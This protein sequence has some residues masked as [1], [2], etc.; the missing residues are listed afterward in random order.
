MLLI[1]EDGPSMVSVRWQYGRGHCET[2][3]EYSQSSIR[4]GVGAG[5]REHDGLFGG[6]GP[7]KAIRLELG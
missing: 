3:A 1:A 4:P 2:T 7:L 6:K 5:E